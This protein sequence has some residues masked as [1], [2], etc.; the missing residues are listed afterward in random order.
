MIYGGADLLPFGNLLGNSYPE[1]VDPNDLDHQY[2]VNIWELTEEGQVAW[3]VGIKGLN[4]MLKVLNSDEMYFKVQEARHLPTG[5]NI[6]MAERFYNEIPLGEVCVAERSDR[7]LLVRIEAYNTVRTQTNQRGSAKLYMITSVGNILLNKFDLDFRRSFGK[8][9][10]FV[11]I[12]SDYSETE[13]VI[14]ITNSWDEVN[15]YNLPENFYSSMS[16]C[17]N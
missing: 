6:F 11:D 5:W 4:P 10:A 7:G 9:F 2:H 14:E 16:L 1:A 17:M 8:S 12:P 13:L 3:R 15:Q